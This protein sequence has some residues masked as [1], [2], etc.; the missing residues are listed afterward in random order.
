MLYVVSPTLTM[1]HS[2]PSA[3]LGGGEKSRSLKFDKVQ[4]SPAYHRAEYL[5]IRLV[6][7]SFLVL[8][9][10]FFHILRKILSSGDEGIR[11]P[12]LR[13]ARAALSQLSYIPEKFFNVGGPFRART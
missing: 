1:A 2:L 3:T 9:V 4:I 5:Q 6:L 10:T 13:R 11:T 8:F 12:D 7:P